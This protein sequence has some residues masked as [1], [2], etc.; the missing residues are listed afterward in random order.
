MPDL[1]CDYHGALMDAAFFENEFSSHLKNGLQEINIY[2][3]ETFRAEVLQYKMILPPDKRTVY[4]VN[5]AFLNRH[6]TLKELS[7]D[8]CGEN[9]GNLHYDT[10]GILTMLENQKKKYILITADQLLIQRVILH[11][12]Q[13]DIYDLK[14]NKFIY[15]HQFYLCKDQVRIENNKDNLTG[16]P[17]YITENMPLYLAGGRRIFLG[18]LI[19]SGGEANIYHMSGN[20]SLVVKV[21]KK[22]KLDEGKYRNIQDIQGMNKTLGIHWALFPIDIVYYDSLCTIPAGFTEEYS[23]AEENL[24]ENP[25]YLGNLNIPAIYWNTNISDSLALCLKIVRQVRYLN[26]FGFLISD[27]NLGNFAIPMCGSEK[28]QM[29]DTDSFGYN[30]YFSGYCSG[31]KT[32]RDYDVSKKEDAISYCNEALYIFV[33]QILSLGDAPISEY[34]RRFKYGKPEYP[35]LFRQ[36]LFPEKLWKLFADVFS[37]KTDPSA[38]LLLQQLYF[39]LQRCNEGTEAD[40]TYKELLPEI[41]TENEPDK[42]WRVIFQIAIIIVAIVLVICVLMM[43]NF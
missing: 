23:G 27:F 14:K 10:W 26:S 30:G 18:G 28:V 17:D 33:F 32:S 35:G 11:G 7:M 13:I 22:G 25:L 42:D 15:Q 38:E 8:S 9:N 12:R 41:F 1:F 39:A 4:D 16:V 6:I 2:V 37:G 20:G 21:F 34:D 29:W 43:R 19:K 24:S 3:A 36:K 31:C 40:P 5:I